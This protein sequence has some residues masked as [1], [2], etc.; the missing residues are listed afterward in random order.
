MDYSICILFFLTCLSLVAHSSPGLYF[1]AW[2]SGTSW[3]VQ[4]C[5]CGA[6][7]AGTTPLPLLLPASSCQD[8]KFALAHTLHVL[9]VHALC[10]CGSI[11]WV[12][13]QADFVSC[14]WYSASHGQEWPLKFVVLVDTGNLM[15]WKVFSMLQILCCHLAWGLQVPGG[16]CFSAD[17]RQSLC[18][19]EACLQCGQCWELW[20]WSRGGGA[21]Q[22]LYKYTQQAKIQVLKDWVAMVIDLNQITC[23]SVFT[24]CACVVTA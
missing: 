9:F 17:S 14:G 3:W 8:C 23:G 1:S 12:P 16:L 24:A 19:A 15:D 5:L 7:A 10:V 2:L 6:G 18:L 13:G 20:W 11:L 22:L 21:L 4:L